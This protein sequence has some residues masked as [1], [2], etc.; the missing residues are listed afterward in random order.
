MGTIC[1]TPAVQDDFGPMNN[2]EHFDFLPMVLAAISLIPHKHF[3]FETIRE[4]PE[5]KKE[6]LAGHLI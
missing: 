6:K 3:N 5:Q 2:F 4:I 1:D